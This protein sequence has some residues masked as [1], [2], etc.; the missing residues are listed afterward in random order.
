MQRVELPICLVP[1][2]RV[3]EVTSGEEQRLQAFFEANPEYFLAVNG[4]P[5]GI[6][7]AREE[8][9]S[10]VPAG[11]G[12]T[13]KWLL[14]YL[15]SEGEFVALANVISDLLASGVWHVGLFIVSTSRHGSGLARALY[16]ELETW[17]ASSG[18]SWLRLGVVQGNVR[19]ERFWKSQGY[20]EARTREGVEM[21]KLTNILRVMFKPLC[22][23]APE[24][25]LT[26]VQRDRPE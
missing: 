2:L 10:Q 23:G 14:G 7:E 5:A 13:K 19:A 6:S 20:I 24:Q 9:H 3:I 1:G 11:W 8:I 18:A 17:A 15:N 16:H 26:L 25:Y 4:E 22:G 12:F 21:G